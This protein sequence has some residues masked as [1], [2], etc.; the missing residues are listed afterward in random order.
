M[1]KSNSVGSRA[2]WDRVMTC[3]PRSSM[4]RKRRL[5]VGQDQG[6]EVSEFPLGPEFGFEHDLTFEVVGLNPGQIREHNLSARPTKFSRRNPDFEGDSTDLDA[7][8]RPLLRDWVRECI[9][10]FIPDGHLEDVEKLEEDE[11]GE[12]EE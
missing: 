6:S 12:L 9:M 1:K 5:E 7:V 3:E 11:K 10:R 2:A 8:P 4:L